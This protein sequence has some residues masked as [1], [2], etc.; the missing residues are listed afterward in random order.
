MILKMRSVTM[1]QKLKRNEFSNNKPN[2]KPNLNK[3]DTGKDMT[4]KKTTWTITVGEINTK[5]IKQ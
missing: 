2:R 4:H 5:R 1:E 3:E